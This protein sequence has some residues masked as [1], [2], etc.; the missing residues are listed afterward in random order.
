[1]N[2]YE[3]AMYN[4][5]DTVRRMTKLIP[6][7]VAGGDH[8]QAIFNSTRLVLARVETALL[9]WRR[10]QDPVSELE[11]GYEAYRNMEELIDDV[12]PG[13][14]RNVWWDLFAVAFSLIGKHVDARALPSLVD[15]EL[16]VGVRFV[17]YSRYLSWLV[18]DLPVDARVRS[19]VL[20][21]LD[22]KKGLVENTYRTYLMLLGDI[23]ADDGASSLVE[24]AHENWRRR[25][26]DRFFEGLSTYEGY[27]EFNELWVDRNLACVLKRINWEGDSVHRW[28]WS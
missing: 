8:D 16:T 15:D 13:Y 23:P 27:G 10:E 2:P 24:R 18:N 21:F 1:M 26:R 3:R 22:S 28:R 12:L 11:Y 4:H 7:Q 17:A 25:A 6:G 5:A 19:K 14:K 20:E 9:K